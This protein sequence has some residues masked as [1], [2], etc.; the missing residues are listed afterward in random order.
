MH[1]TEWK[2][3]CFIQISLKLALGGIMAWRR[4]GRKPLAESMLTQMYDAIR[5][6]R[7]KACCMFNTK[8]LLGTNVDSWLVSLGHNELTHL[9]LVYASVNQVSIGTDNGLSPSHY[10]NQCCVIFNWIHRKQLQWNFNQNTKFS[11]TKMHPKT[12]SG[13]W[14][15]FCAGGDEIIRCLHVAIAVVTILIPCHSLSNHCNSF[16]DLVQ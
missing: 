7:H 15:P 9:H 6:Q 16:E 14:R 2:F 12:S 8:P 13:K 10:L 11:F 1:F 3:Y 4:A 5:C